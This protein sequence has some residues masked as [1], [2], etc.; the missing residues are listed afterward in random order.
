MQGSLDGKARRLRELRDEGAISDEDYR[1]MVLD[2][3]DAEGD[4]SA[5]SPEHMPAEKPLPAPSPGKPPEK[6]EPPEP[7]P[8]DKVPEPPK[9]MR[10]GMSSEDAVPDGATGP[11]PEG[12]PLPD[13][14][15]GE[16]EHEESAKVGRLGRLTKR[17][18]VL[19]AVAAV[20]LV[21][22]AAVGYGFWTG[23][24][25]FKP[26]DIS[27]EYWDAGRRARAVG[28]DYL[29]GKV[30][31]QEAKAE[32]EKV[33][34]S[35]EPWNVTGNPALPLKEVL[36]DQFIYRAIN[37]LK[38]AIDRSARAERLDQ[39]ASDDRVRDAMHSLE[40]ALRE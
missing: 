9:P 10:D 30:T 13:T 37:E 34:V 32:L 19:I 20:A 1:R 22:L 15:D 31:A 14:Q 40:Q 39:S 12:S 21:A 29:G 36:N 17:G 5:V 25:A 23:D 2:L 24:I 38:G 3:V 16:A 28:R 8:M 26:N 33:S 27:Q 4:S 18:K 7:T 6:G 35:D 11:E